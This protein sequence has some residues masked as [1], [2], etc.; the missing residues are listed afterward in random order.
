MEYSIIGGGITGLYLAYQLIKQGNTVTIYEISNRLGGRILTERI[1]DYWFNMGAARYLPS[2]HTL[3]VSLISELK[4]PTES[5]INTVCT[6]ETYRNLLSKLPL[7]P[8]TGN[9]VSVATT[10]ISKEDIVFL[11]RS[12]GY[13]LILDAKCPYELGYGLIA[14]VLRT[15]YRTITGGMDRLITRL[16]EVCGDKLKIVYNTD[17][18]PLLPCLSNVIVTIPLLSLINYG[19]YP[20]PENRFLVSARKIGYSGYGN[21]YQA[22]SYNYGQVRYGMGILQYQTWTESTRMYMNFTPKPSRSYCLVP[23]NDRLLT[24][25]VWD[26][27]AWFPSLPLSI[28]YVTINGKSYP[29]LSNDVSNETGWINGSLRLVDYYLSTL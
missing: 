24:M 6:C 20:Y 12:S 19:Y 8:Q 9:F 18:I 25:K 13:T 23:S 29:Y 22:L 21:K 16:V 7:P 3:L 5:Y 17:G 28:T 10:Y 15:D 27:L 26:A 2:E 1:E 4:L 11:A 14:S